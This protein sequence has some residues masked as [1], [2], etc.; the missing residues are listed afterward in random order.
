MS[1][2]RAGRSALY[3]A[4]SMIAALLRLVLRDA[5]SGGSACRFRRLRPV[6]VGGRV[7]LGQVILSPW[8]GFG[9]PGLLGSPFAVWD[10][11]QRR[12]GAGPIPPRHVVQR[13]A[14]YYYWK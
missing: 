9:G 11:P 2:Q 10:F 8:D 13:W 5:V 12:V 4:G 14:Y 1:S 6:M 3:A 7:A